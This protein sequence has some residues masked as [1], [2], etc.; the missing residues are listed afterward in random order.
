MMLAAEGSPVPSRGSREAVPRPRRAPALGRETLV[1]TVP[2]PSQL[3]TTI[4]WPSWLAPLG[5]SWRK[6]LTRSNA[7]RTIQE[8]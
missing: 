1:L 6:S 8:P 4:R 3:E 5:A 7:E 2:A